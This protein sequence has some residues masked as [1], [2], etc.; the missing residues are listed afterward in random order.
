MLK[1]TSQRTTINQTKIKDDFW[2]QWIDIISTKTIPYQWKALNDEIEGAPPSHSVE[3][4][5]I[6]SGQSSGTFHGMPF[7]DSDVYKWIE[8]ASYSLIHYPDQELEAK[9]DELIELIRQAQQDDGYINTYYTVAKPNERWT[10]FSHGHEL[11]CAG[12]LIEAAVAYYEVTNK[13]TL[14][15][16]ANMF[17]DYIDSMF[18]IEDGKRKIYPGHEEIE[19]ALMRLY[20]VTGNKMHLNL[21]I[22]FI[23]ERGT[24]PSFLLEENTLIGERDRWFGLDYHQAHATVRE[25]TTAHG[26]A[27]RAMY[28]YTGMADIAKETGDEEL[29]K[30]LKRLW[31]NVTNQKMYLTGGIGSQGHGERFTAEYDLPN[32]V[33]YAETCASIGLMFWAMRMLE[34]ENDR[35]YADVMETALYNGVLSGIS[36]EG[37]KYFYVNPLEV[38]PSAVEERFD[39][40]HVEPERVPWFGCA[41]CP[42][43]IAR[44]ITS[45][46]QYMYTTSENKINV[47]LYIGS[48]TEF[49]LDGKKFEIIQK[50]NYPTDG[51]ILFDI[52]PEKPTTHEIC[53]RIPAW[54]K[55]FTVKI[56]NQVIDSPINDDG[57]ITLSKE[58]KE[59]DTIELELPLL[60]EKIRAN[61]RVR[62]NIGKIALKRGPVVYCLEQE[63][64]GPHLKNIF[65]PR[66]ETPILNSL[67]N[68]TSLE[69]KGVRYEEDQWE[70]NLYSSH[71]PVRKPM[72]VKAVPYHIWGNRSPR[73]EMLVWM[74]EI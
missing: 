26:H 27:V 47:H 33:A 36:L 11:Y 25:Q 71:E 22:Y 39:H 40:K 1:V 74:N 59:K 73:E 19:L 7:Q 67:D 30:V 56:N 41:C 43:N 15:A 32:D 5:R 18:G 52:H 42:P 69:I 4:F 46:G 72:M 58:W 31:N 49:N 60:V 57:Y 28:L 61:P 6:A 37:T 64:N 66:D 9:I 16:I 8:A 62:E 63:D 24:Q 12:H 48:Q 13:D 55:D 3:N 17:V 35:Q 51:K 20:K 50:T 38:F 44:L 10:D 70:G 2:S 14:L 45:I 54:C 21:C 29:K 34:L 53:L 23:N 68:I 65:I